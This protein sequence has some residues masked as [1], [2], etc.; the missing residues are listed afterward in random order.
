MDVGL[1]TGMTSE[2][3][4][5]DKDVREG[6]GTGFADLLNEPATAKRPAAKAA[7]REAPAAE[8]GREK[9]V[10]T[11]AKTSET[12]AITEKK[13]VRAASVET[14]E[15]TAPAPVQNPANGET[16]NPADVSL[17]SLSAAETV[18]P[19]EN[20]LTQ[21]QQNPANV[22]V[23][24]PD[25]KAPPTG[26]AS[27]PAGI[28][29]AAPANAVIAQ[30][31]MAPSASPATAQPI[32]TAAPGA[33]I[34]PSGENDTPAAQ[35]QQ[36][37]VNEV[38]ARGVKEKTP[39]TAGAPLNNAAGEP[40]TD[41]A[42]S[43]ALTTVR[44][45][46]EAKMSEKDMLAAKISE[47]LRDGNGSITA[48]SAKAHTGQPGLAS[49]ATLMNAGLAATPAGSAP[50]LA[51]NLVAASAAPVNMEAALAQSAAPAIGGAAAATPDAGGQMIPAIPTGAVQSVDATSASTMSQAANAARAHHLPVA[52]QLSVHINTAIKEGQD[53][54]KVS[55]HPSELGRVE[56]KLDIGHDGRILAAVAVDRQETLDLLQRDARALERA[57]QNAG[58][59]TGSNSL[60]F[61]LQQERGGEQERREAFAGGAGAAQS[62]S[63]ETASV[64]MARPAYGRSGRTDGSLDI[65]V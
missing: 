46:A 6:G 30:Q 56:V 44:G 47:M 45:D 60:S 32:N 1:I 43:K 64:E 59:E 49:A 19:I 34:A 9:A 4:R 63:D 13:P 40:V 62:L 36:I 18:P 39:A 3:P 27:A 22:A 11:R 52:E 16:P 41:T 51:A 26:N 31:E 7:E 10:E 2:Q 50:G 20:A 33:S 65:Q 37:Q 12:P 58:F 25:G 42:A 14:N 5:R 23:A 29:P 24:A 55:L 57:L 61:S 21:S 8:G 28:A 53:R 17:P 54:I 48:T 35:I 38:V 15:T